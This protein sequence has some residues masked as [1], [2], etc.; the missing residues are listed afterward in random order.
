MTQSL[1][2]G[3]GTSGSATAGVPAS[4][5]PRGR[6][7][8]SRQ[9][10]IVPCKDGFVRLCVLA[11]RQWRGLFEWM[12]SPDEFADPAFANNQY[13][14]ASD[15][16]VPRIAGFFAD[17]TR[18]RIE[19]EGARHRVPAVGLLTLDE[20]LA[21]DHIRARGAL[22]EVEIGPGLIAPFPD[23]VMEID[24]VRAG[25]KGP[26]PSADGDIDA[27]L[28]AWSQPR[29]KY[30]V[31][32]RFG[33]PGR[34]LAGLR[35]PDLGVIVVGSEQGRLLADYGAD[36]IKIENAAFPDGARNGKRGVSVT[37]AA[38]HRNKRGLGLNLRDP[39]GRALF[40][41]LA[42]QADVV[43]SNF[44]PGTLES[45]D[46]GPDVLLAHNPRLIL[47]DS[48]AF[49]ATGPWSGRM[50]YGPLVRASA[51]LTN[52]WRYAGEP[53]GFSDAM[54]VY[55]DH[56]AARIGIAG[57]LA[58]LIR[59]WRTGR[60]GTVSVSQ[61]EV[62]LSH[63]A[64][65]IAGPACRGASARRSARRLPPWPCRAVAWAAPAGWRCRSGRPARHRCD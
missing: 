58:L 64:A 36:V 28:S 65:E 8:A 5:L 27:V 40:L 14:V 39:E 38:G 34:P 10:P 47:A 31:Q 12:G 44:K 42:E 41:K 4:Q 37:F 50:G 53:D 60:G 21:G 11:P 46:L 62:M 26:P 54:T 3:Y 32:G 18:A 49:G 22:I 16:L 63:M 52:Q 7:D 9:Y 13:R 25:T 17:K 35:V 15:T 33:A 57:V 51:G 55:P 48:S 29:A 59:R 2:P 61:T 30:E 1:D 56:V 23:G 43:L 45:L 6:P 24:G 20:A 19:V